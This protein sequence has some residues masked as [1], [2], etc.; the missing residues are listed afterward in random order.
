MVK[1]PKGSKLIDE[2]E[3]VSLYEMPPDPR[4]KY[5]LWKAEALQK[6]VDRARD[7]IEQF[8]RHI[9]DLEKTITER[10]A[11]IKVCEE[12]DRAIAEWERNRGNSD[13]PPGD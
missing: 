7:Q 8:R 2:G 10:E 5:P 6:D 3:G 13:F 1:L 12:R 11:L 9:E 4:K